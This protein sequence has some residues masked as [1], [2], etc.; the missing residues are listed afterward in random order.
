MPKG[1]LKLRDLINRLKEFGVVAMVNKR[2]KGSEIILV[3]PVSPDSKKGPQ[4]P[5]KNHGDGTEIYV[6][7]IRAALRRFEIPEDDFWK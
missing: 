2:G 3:K 5:I 6:P 1:P 4:F 7:V